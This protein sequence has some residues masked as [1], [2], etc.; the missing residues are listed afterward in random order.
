M[1]WGI[2]DPRMTTTRRDDCGGK[3][4]RPWF[5]LNNRAMGTTM[6]PGAAQHLLVIGCWVST[7][8]YVVVEGERWEDLGC[9]VLAGRLSG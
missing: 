6:I 7:T 1:L 5:T 2:I 4:G 3:C 9:L 8:Q